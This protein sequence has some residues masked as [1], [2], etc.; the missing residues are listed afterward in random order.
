MYEQPTPLIKKEEKDIAQEL[1]TL[2]TQ[3]NI[4]ISEADNNT[5]KN[6]DRF[7]KTLKEKV[8][9]LKTES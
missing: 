8:E 9:K 2:E 3:L 1:N 7:R 4:A 6:S 5:T